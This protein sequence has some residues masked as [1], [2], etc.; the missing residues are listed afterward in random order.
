MRPIPLLIHKDKLELTEYWTKVAKQ[1]VIDNEGRPVRAEINI[2]IPE[3]KKQR[4]FYYGA[5]LP[6]WAYLDGADFRKGEII[7]QYHEIAKIEFNGEIVVSKG[8]EYRIGKSSRGEL[9]KGYLERV[10]DNLVD[11]YGINP[12]EV[13]NPETYKTFRDTIYQHTTIDDYITYL[14]KCGKLR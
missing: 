6:L 11:Q 13:L 1:A 3:S 7:D 8:K 5:V 2:T 9:N 4:A 14:I 10:I 12:M